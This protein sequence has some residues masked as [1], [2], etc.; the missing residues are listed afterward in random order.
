[1][2]ITDGG[3]VVRCRTATAT[4]AAVA[5]LLAPLWTGATAAVARPT[6]PRTTAGVA[7]ALPSL[8]SAV[9]WTSCADSDLD[10]S[11]AVCAKLQVPLDYKR[12]TGPK[13]SLAL[14]M[15]KHTSRDGAYQGIMLV[16]PGG[17]GGSGIGLAT[18]GQYVPRNAGST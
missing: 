5:V 3:P 2:R 6:A 7:A 12:P 16:N 10:S 9:R 11:G 4:L 17:P 18:L 14:S 1:M 15:V 8:A 13:I